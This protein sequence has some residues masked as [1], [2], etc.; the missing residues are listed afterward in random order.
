MFCFFFFFFCRLK[1][2]RCKSESVVKAR[3]RLIGLMRISVFYSVYMI[4][5]SID[6]VYYSFIKCNVH[7]NCHVIYLWKCMQ[8]I[9]ID[10]NKFNKSLVGKSL[11]LDILN[12]KQNLFFHINCLLQ[13]LERSEKHFFFFSYIFGSLC[14]TLYITNTA[15]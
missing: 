1:C 7:C 15:I 4:T 2:V 10:Q 13:H 12:F 11:A 5:L 3:Q 14:E 9:S 8:S 6:K